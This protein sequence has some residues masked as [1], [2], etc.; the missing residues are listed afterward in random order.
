M[1]WADWKG[2]TK[3]DDSERPNQVWNSDQI[4]RISRI[5]PT[6][7]LGSIDQT[8]GLRRIEPT[9]RLGTIESSRKDRP[10]GRAKTY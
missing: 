1:V 8:I 9:R 4:M 5:K 6:Q 7:R 10:D 2:L 3:F